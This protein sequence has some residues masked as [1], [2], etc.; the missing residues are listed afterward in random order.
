MP[1]PSNK[2][3]PKQ[4]P[5]KKSKKTA[6]SKEKMPKAT[7]SAPV[8]T[9]KIIRTQAPK[10]DRSTKNGDIVIRHREFVA[11]IPGSV[12]FSVNTFSVNPGL[13]LLFPWLSLQAPQYESYRVVKIDFEFQTM[14]STATPGTVMAAIDYDPSDPAP[15]T[16]TQMAAYRHFVRSAPWQ[17][18]VHTSLK[19]DLNKRSSYFVRT[20][21][22][23]AG[24][25]V[26]LYD[27]G[28]FYIA[29]VGQTDTTVVGEL[30]VTYEIK[31]MTPQL[32][33]VGTGTTKSSAIT[34]NNGIPPR[35]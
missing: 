7:H 28:N 21:P 35:S 1:Q 13:T 32:G 22:L 33:N 19:V 11:D 27:V 30:Y 3:Q 18:F 34:F 23:G 4:N 24:Q 26:K 2:K 9:T 8:A 12:T 15:T 10:I 20:G 17:G 25:D 6:Q 31:L 16:K 29:T 5:K 14:S